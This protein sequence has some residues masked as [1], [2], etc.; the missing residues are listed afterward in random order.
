MFLSVEDDGIG[1]DVEAVKE[2]GG[3]G[4]ISMEERAR[5]VNGTLSIEAQPGHG[6]R[7]SLTIPLPGN[8]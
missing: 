6:A 7:I 8:S 3:L 4:L 1:F 5:L 2:R